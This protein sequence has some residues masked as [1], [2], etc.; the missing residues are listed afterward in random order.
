M[1]INVI[2]LLYIIKIYLIFSDF[3]LWMKKLR[4]R[5]VIKFFKV[6]VYLINVKFWVIYLLVKVFFL[7][8]VRVRV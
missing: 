7:V 1:F 3:I 4:F 2:N 5:E 8:S 6:L